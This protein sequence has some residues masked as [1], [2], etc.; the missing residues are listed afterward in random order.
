MPPPSPFE[1]QREFFGRFPGAFSVMELFESLP[2]AFFYAKDRESRF[3]RV[4]AAFRA[5]HGASSDEE[6]LGRT[7]RDFSPPLLAEAYIA[8]DRRV[9]AEAKALPGQLWLVFHPKQQPH[10]YVSTKVP[11]F[12]PSGAVI[13]I[14]GV[15]YL[16]EQ[17]EEQARYFGALQPAMRWMETRYTEPVSMQEMAALTGLSATHFNRRFKQ[18]L[19]ATPTEHLRNI[20]VRVACRLLSSTPRPISAIA[21]ETGFTDQSHFTRCF[22]KNTGLTPRAYRIRFQK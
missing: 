21:L 13:G 2:D 10:W 4:N 8:E 22:R 16:I 14:A 6:I 11:L 7:D 18:L 19:R 5:S 20:R 15:M 17:P 9:M 1:F 3:I 12:D